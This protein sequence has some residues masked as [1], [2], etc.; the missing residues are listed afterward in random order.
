VYFLASGDVTISGTMDLS[1][2]ASYGAISFT[3]LR[4]PNAAGSGASQVE[5]GV[6]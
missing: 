1:G 6:W 2:D 5:S 3:S 4:V